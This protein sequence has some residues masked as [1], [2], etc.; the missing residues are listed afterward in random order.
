MTATSSQIEGAF[1]PRIWIGHDRARNIVARNYL[2]KLGWD[3]RL[4]RNPNLVDVRSR[5][6]GPYYSVGNFCPCPSRQRP[7]KHIRVAKQFGGVKAL[8]EALNAAE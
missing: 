3:F 2:R 1:R 7:C 6:N 4:N 5:E 8:R